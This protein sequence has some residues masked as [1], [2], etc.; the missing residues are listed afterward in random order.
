MSLRSHDKKK[1]T[2]KL[3][4]LS[5]H[6]GLN[7]SFNFEEID[8]CL[9]DQQKMHYLASFFCTSL[10]FVVF[11]SSNKT[12][13]KN[14]SLSWNFKWMA[15]TLPWMQKIICFFSKKKTNFNPKIK[16]FRRL[17]TFDCRGQINH[18]WTKY[19]KRFAQNILKSTDNNATM[20]ND[21]ATV[22]TCTLDTLVNRFSFSC[23]LFQCKRLI[24]RMIFIHFTIIMKTFSSINYCRFCVV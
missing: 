9:K 6:N 19:N 22:A 4:F 21:G 15:F 24:E 1:I 12:K 16:F 14:I 3:F 2:K 8:V 17:F 5:S 7:A 20:L 11:C 23:L 10:S 13:K 18:H